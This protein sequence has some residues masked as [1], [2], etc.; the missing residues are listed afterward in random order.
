MKA[1]ETIWQ[2]FER[3]WTS[4]DKFGKDLDVRRPG[5]PIL[6]LLGRHAIKIV[7]L[8]RRRRGALGGDKVKIFASMASSQE[9]Q[10]FGYGFWTTQTHLKT[11][12]SATE[13]AKAA[14]FPNDL[15]SFCAK[16]APVFGKYCWSGGI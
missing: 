14:R 8:T 11:T 5:T 12:G 6:A 16:K 2:G 15:R 7:I 9:G 13:A 1:F 4:R 10:R 3:T